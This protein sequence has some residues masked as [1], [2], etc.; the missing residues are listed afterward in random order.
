MKPYQM[1]TNTSILATDSFIFPIFLSFALSQLASQP[2]A[3]TYTNTRTHIQFTGTI[4]LIL[5]TF[6]FLFKFILIPKKQFNAIAKYK[7]K[8]K[9]SKILKLTQLPH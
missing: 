7:R 8:E 6:F 3:H 2:T 4:I 5:L 1:Q 9:K